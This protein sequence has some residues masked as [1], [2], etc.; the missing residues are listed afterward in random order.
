MLIIDDNASRERTLS[1][2]AHVSN[3][4]SLSASPI[5]NNAGSIIVITNELRTLNKEMTSVKDK[6]DEMSLDLHLLVEMTRSQMNMFKF[7]FVSLI[8][9]DLLAFKK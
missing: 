1:M 8:R 7:C 6:I 4:S 9:L 3:S 2:K 5:S